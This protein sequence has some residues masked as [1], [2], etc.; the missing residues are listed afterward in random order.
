M[1]KRKESY[2]HTLPATFDY[3]SAGNWQTYT[4]K[5]LLKIA[6]YR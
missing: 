3:F 1:D 6:Q 2:Y 4:K 5:M